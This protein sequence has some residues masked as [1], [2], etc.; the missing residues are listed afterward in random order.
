MLGIS[1]VALA[2]VAAACGDSDGDDA[3]SIESNPW[4]LT[5]LQSEDG[6]LDEALAAVDITAR[7][8]PGEV[9]GD[10]GCNRYFGPWTS[11]GVSIDIGPLASTRRACAEPINQQEFRYLTLMQTAVRYEVDSERLTLFDEDGNE[12]LLFTAIERTELAGSSWDAIG[13]NT[14]QE[15]VVSL[16]IGTEITARFDEDGNLSGTGG[17]NQYTAQYEA[18]EDTI[19]IVAIAATE[20]ACSEPEGVMEQEQ[21]Y[22]AALER[23]DTWSVESGRL[24]LRDA[25]GALQASY[26]EAGE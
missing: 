15:A 23:A 1:L 12:S 16:I 25:G 14:G 4:Q 22:F 26:E 2:V 3:G 18:T 7:F 20:R 21:Q 9:T 19:S 10:G 8:V 24:E 11:A 6:D 5:E 13:V 17:C